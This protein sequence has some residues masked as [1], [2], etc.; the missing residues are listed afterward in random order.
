KFKR[1]SGFP[2][3]S[4]HTAEVAGLVD[5]YIRR[6]L[7][8]QEFDPAEADNWKVLRVDIVIDHI[9]AQ[10]AGLIVAAQEQTEAPKDSEVLLTALPTVARLKVREGY[11][12]ELR[13]CIY[14][15]TPY[16]SNKG[17]YERDFMEYADNDGAVDA[18]AK[19]V[20]NVHTFVRFRYVREDGLPAQYIPDF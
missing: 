4:V 15:R 16:P 19:V 18:L 5:G 20:E 14:D 2:A 9:V 3:L 8:S 12:L 11:S 6:R 7:F 10:V 17:E 13:K 1:D